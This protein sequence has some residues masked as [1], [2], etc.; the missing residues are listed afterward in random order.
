MDRPGIIR[1]PAVGGLFYPGS[2]AALT[3]DLAGMIAR[4]QGARHS[5]RVLG[6][7]SPHAGYVYSGATAA[8]AYARLVG[9]SYDT[10]VIVSP[11]HREFFEGVSVYSGDGYRTPIGTVSVN[12]AL[13]SRLL[14]ECPIVR[15]SESG[16]GEEHA[17]EVQIPFLQHVLREFQILP[18]VIGDQRRENCFALGEAL[19]RILQGASA[20]LVASTDLSHYHPSSV[21]KRLD[22]VFQQDVE[23]FD[24]EQLMKDLEDGTTEA[25]GGG[26]SVAVMKALADLGA[27]TME[28]AYQCNSGDVTGDTS[29]VVGYLSA[30]AYA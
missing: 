9:Q 12:A 4:A 6:I 15:A 8:A 5:G 28:V 14:A 16:H 24:C 30:V 11:S 2:P 1:P 29:A 18:L 20:L 19:A 26:P 3:R 22:R 13:R 10:V 17:I 27:H 23:R 21:A 7:L 25:C